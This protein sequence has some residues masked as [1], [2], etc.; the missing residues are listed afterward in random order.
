M[1]RSKIPPEL[2]KLWNST[3]AAPDE[4]NPPPPRPTA[5]AK[6]KAK[7][8]ATA[9]ETSTRFATLNTFTD[10]TLRELCRAE[11]AVWLTLY[12]D[13]KPDGLARTSQ[14]DVAR[15]TGLNVGTVKRAVARLCRRGLLTAVSRGN[16]H[17]GPSVYRVHPLTGGYKK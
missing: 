11:L 16:V 14:A 10:V 9:A 17:R 5:G 1:T 8:K 15:R 4:P 12:R 6:T 7:G 13:T 2:L 3:E